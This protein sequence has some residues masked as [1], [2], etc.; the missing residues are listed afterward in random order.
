MSSNLGVHLKSYTGDEGG[1]G[2]PEGFGL[3][4]YATKQVEFEGSWRAG[5]PAGNGVFRYPNGLFVRLCVARP[6]APDFEERPNLVSPGYVWP[7]RAACTGESPRAYLTLGSAHDP[8][9]AR[10]YTCTARDDGRLQFVA[11]QDGAGGAL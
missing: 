2:A 7:Q 5:R 10:T 4:V 6:T 8:G 9:A 3:G 11:V 1:D